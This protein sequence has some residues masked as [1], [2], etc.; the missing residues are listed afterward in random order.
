[1]L[2]AAALAARKGARI[3][4][5]THARLARA[6]LPSAVWPRSTRE[7]FV[8]LLACGRDAILVIEALDHTRLWEHYLPEW[9]VV[10]ALPQRNAYHR[11]TVDRHLLE[12]A[13]NAAALTDRVARPDLLLVGA[14]LHDIGKGR[15]GD[16]TEVGMVLVDEIGHR[17]GFRDADVAV[18]V[19]LVR[20]HLLLPEVAIRRD[21]SD[22]ATIAS[23]AEQV[24]D[25]NRLELLA[26]LTEADSLATGVAAWGT[27]KAE[28]VRELV[29]RADHYLAGGD[30]SALVTT[31]FPDAAQRALLVAGE[32][33]VRGEGDT[34]I[35][36]A[37]D[38]PGLFSR[39]AGALALQGL[40]VLSADAAGED[41]MAIE[42][43]R[44]TAKAGVTIAWDRVI[45]RVHAALEGRLAIEARLAERVRTYARPNA[46][47]SITPP[48]VYFDDAASRVATVVEVHAPDFIGLLY[49]VTRAF[50]EFDL[51]V[52]V[53]K[54]QTLGDMVV[55]AF[56][57]TD[58]QGGLVIDPKVRAELERALLHA[59]S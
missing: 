13:A 32:T 20:L 50:A 17:M 49:R 45:D 15:P 28:L 56:Y 55:D 1:V 37:P 30:L 42:S 27:W 52:R 3:A 31:D 44:V 18:L 24:G 21:L 38:R 29:R 41:G 19:D 12:T 5:D 14:L 46:T 51:D 58:S 9:E 36:I 59:V 11:F 43:I 40:E 23:V 34:L 48:T 22:D 47:R 33:V 25:R 54:V 10:R 53:A 2:E 39:V 8:D 7:R 4:R 57:V 16:H 35:V 6:P 26:A